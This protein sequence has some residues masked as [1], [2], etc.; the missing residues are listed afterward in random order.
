MRFRVFFIRFVTKANAAARLRRALGSLPV[1]PLRKAL[2]PAAR[3][4]FP[5]QCG[6]VWGVE[7]DVHVGEVDRQFHGQVQTNV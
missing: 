5:A 1:G 7:L 6:V 2:V 4:V 3:P